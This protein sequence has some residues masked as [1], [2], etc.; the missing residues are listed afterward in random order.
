MGGMDRMGLWG[1]PRL[2]LLL[3]LL[4]LWVSGLRGEDEEQMC[5]L[6]GSNLTI[7]CLYTRQYAS[8]LKAWQRVRSRGPPETLV[9]TD[10]R[11]ADLN[12][13]QAGRYLL[14][15]DP[16]EVMFR[17]TMRELQR[18]DVGLY[19]CVIDLSPQ[20][21]VVLPPRIRLV[22]C[23]GLPP[24]L[25]LSEPQ[26][27]A[28]VLTCGF[29]LNKGLVFSVLIVLLRKARAS[30]EWGPRPGLGWK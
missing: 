11:V 6:E 21:P 27:M 10:T 14:E 22:P 2:L 17:V 18:Q 1:R 26:V 28:I 30:G 24:A 3:L 7:S 12:M 23:E 5:L 13:A 16:N 25:A 4:L 19:Q 20:T 9:R 15:D 8:S 29:I